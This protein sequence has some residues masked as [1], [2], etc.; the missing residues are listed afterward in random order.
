MTETI[1]PD[2]LESLDIVVLE[3]REPGR[4]VTVGYGAGMV[5]RALSGS[6]VHGGIYAR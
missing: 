6:S 1:L 5:R 2:L 4:F 3:R